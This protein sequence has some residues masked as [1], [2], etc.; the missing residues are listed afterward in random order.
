MRNCVPV[1]RDC[2]RTRAFHAASRRRG[3]IAPISR[4]ARPT[5]IERASR[6]GVNGALTLPVCQLI[7]APARRRTHDFAVSLR[8]HAER[9]RFGGGAGGRAGARAA[10]DRKRRGGGNGGS[11]SAYAG[12][13]GS[14]KK[15]KKS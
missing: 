12:R 6:T 2:S 8:P 14:M 10:G 5:A 9:R 11:I 1:A 7:T 13:G 3:R 4:S 15:K